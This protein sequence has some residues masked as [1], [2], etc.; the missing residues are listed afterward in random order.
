VPVLQF[1]PDEGRA[2]HDLVLAVLLLV[3]LQ[4]AADWLR[5]SLGED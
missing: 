2:E 3:S 5:F 4:Q 1:A